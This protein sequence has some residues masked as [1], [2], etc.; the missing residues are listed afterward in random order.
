MFETSQVGP[1][2]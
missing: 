2:F 1:P